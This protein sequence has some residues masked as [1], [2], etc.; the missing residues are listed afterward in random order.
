MRRQTTRA[1][2]QEPNPGQRKTETAKTIV[3]PIMPSIDVQARLNVDGRTAAQSSSRTVN[4]AMDRT[5]QLSAR[6]DQSKRPFKQIQAKACEIPPYVPAPSRVRHM[7][8]VASGAENPSAPSAPAQETNA[9]LL[10]ALPSR[11]EK[12][13]STPRGS[14]ASGAE[15]RPQAAS[16]PVA[17]K[18]PCQTSSSMAPAQDLNFMFKEVPL[19]HFYLSSK[20]AVTPGFKGLPNTLLDRILPPPSSLPVPMVASRKMVLVLYS[21]QR[22]ETCLSRMSQTMY[23]ESTLDFFDVDTQLDPCHN[24]LDD[25]FFWQLL[26]WAHRG[27]LH[28]IVGG[29]NCRTWSILL[30][31]T[32]RGAPQ[33]LRHRTK[34]P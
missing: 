1:K 9:C 16:L 17:S 34:A 12:G 8:T 14:V 20:I 30:F 25:D 19:T 31:Q 26:E 21:G 10:P 23:P 28:A 5:G 33:P 18:S 4:P 6:F 15:T 13:F 11:N 32:K 7:G 3:A 29:P 2:A 24:I 27:Q 22:D